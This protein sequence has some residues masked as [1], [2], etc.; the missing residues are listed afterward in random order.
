VVCHRAQ[1]LKCFWKKEL[2]CPGS[3][4]RAQTAQLFAQFVTNDDVGMRFE[5]L[6]REIGFRR[7]SRLA[8]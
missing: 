7:L 5:K 8:R 1:K 3:E 4:R 6:Q 2:A